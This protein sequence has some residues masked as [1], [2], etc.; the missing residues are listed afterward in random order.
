MPAGLGTFVVKPNVST[1]ICL[2]CFA[3]GHDSFVKLKIYDV[4][5]RLICVPFAGDVSK[6][7]HEKFINTS[8]LSNGTYFAV[9]E[10]ESGQ[11]TGK[12]VISR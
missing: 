12:I 11:R 7:R 6:G 8:Y 10:T 2:A 4:G 3:V 9:L 1:D 5:G